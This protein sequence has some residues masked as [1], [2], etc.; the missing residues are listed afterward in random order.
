MPRG[1]AAQRV[2]DASMRLFSERGYT[3][4][5]MAEIESSSGLTP[6]AGGVYRHFES[7]FEILQTG[8]RDQLD[9]L[10]AIQGSVVDDKPYDLADL[11]TLYVRGGLV[12]IRAQRA[13]VRLL[14]RDLDA[15]PDLLH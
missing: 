12:V 5:T 6:G 13:L 4:T 8:V 9:A 11:L 15:F 2:L 10:D 1:L 14:Y 3:Q 7:K